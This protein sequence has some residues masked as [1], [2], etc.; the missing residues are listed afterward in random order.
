MFQLER[1]AESCLI[2]YFRLSINSNPNSIQGCAR[3]YLFTLKSQQTLIP[4]CQTNWSCDSRR[5]QHRRLCLLKYPMQCLEGILRVR[6]MNFIFLRNLKTTKI[7]VSGGIGA[8]ITPKTHVIRGIKTKFN[9]IYVVRFPIAFFS[10]HADRNR[11]CG[12]GHLRP[13]VVFPVGR[14][15]PASRRDRPCGSRH[16]RPGGRHQTGIRAELLGPPGGCAA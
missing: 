16:L 8:K 2:G 9:P 10:K 5:T 14:D 15:R 1:V 11:P 7:R 12:S 3:S 13:D 4:N 6:L